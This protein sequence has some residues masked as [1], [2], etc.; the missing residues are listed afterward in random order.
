MG[1]DSVC[2]EHAL[3]SRSGA[4]ALARGSY[5]E[6]HKDDRSRLSSLDELR[7]LF[8]CCCSLVVSRPNAGGPVMMR[9]LIVLEMKA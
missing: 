1:R 6:A 5:G 4:L 7:R 2:F 8:C 3:R 9:A